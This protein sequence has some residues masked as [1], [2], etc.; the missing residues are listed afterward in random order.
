M[1]YS[2]SPEL[3]AC[4][5]AARNGDLDAAKQVL[6]LYGYTELVREVRK[7]RPF[8]NRVRRAVNCLTAG[9]G[10]EKW[11]IIRDGA[12]VNMLMHGP[13]A[14]GSPDTRRHRFDD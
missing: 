13:P 2:P 11:E 6:R 9:Y 1:V 4:C 8:S 7:G 5:I 10:S 12:F 14:P 3:R